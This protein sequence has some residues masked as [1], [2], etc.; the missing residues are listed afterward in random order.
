MFVIDCD[1]DAEDH[2]GL[3]GVSLVQ[4]ISNMTDSLQL[5]KRPGLPVFF[6]SI[7]CEH[8]HV[9]NDDRDHDESQCNAGVLAARSP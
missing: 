8:A 5:F 7:R 1:G 2:T 9:K 4:H 6:D 3:D